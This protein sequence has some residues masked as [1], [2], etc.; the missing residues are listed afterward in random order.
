MTSRTIIL[1]VLT[2]VAFAANSILCRMA[3]KA[4]LIDPASFTQIRILSGAAFLAPFFYLR[5]AAVLPLRR[6]DWRPAA[7][8]FI[9]AV[10]FSFAY[11]S[12]SA[13]AGA[14]ILFGAVQFTM[15]GADLARG[16]RP[17]LAQWAGVAIAFAGLVYLFAPGLSAPPLVG[18]ALMAA[19][20][21]AWGVYSLMGK[22]EADPVA[23]T[24]RNFALAAP[25]A[26]AA[27][28]LSGGAHVAPQ[29]AILA[30]LSGALASGAGYVVWYRALKG[31]STMNA[32]V[33]QLAVPAI[34]ALG[35][36]LLL[37]E[38]M[39]L[40]LAVASALILGGIYLAIRKTP[41]GR[42]R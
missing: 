40:R 28:L 23:A 16:A 39:T 8:L 7:A 2:L 27:T 41:R 1:T 15:I 42:A 25:L 22:G 19:A 10:A 37:G 30:V 34:A 4:E 31:L 21:A 12:L 11:V 26:F 6:R 13:A 14:L 17:G 36:V 38:T 29:G 32:A 3:L 33:V 5:R 9:Y 20:G 18:A 24:A 35:G